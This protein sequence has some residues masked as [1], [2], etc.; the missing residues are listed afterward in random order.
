LKYRSNTNEYIADNISEG[1]HIIMNKL[2]PEDISHIKQIF[3]SSL[4]EH[5]CRFPSVTSQ[6]MEMLGEIANT[7]IEV[8]DDA[9]KAA[10]RIF[11]WTLFL[12]AFTAVV[13]CA[14]AFVG[15]L[16]IKLKFLMGGH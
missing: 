7:A 16:W 8:R 12:I 15:T 14:I 13:G 4:A 6:Q 5:A 10:K 1:E 9:K 2:T 3:N 11:K